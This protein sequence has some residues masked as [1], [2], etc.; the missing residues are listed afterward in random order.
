M[1]KKVTILDTKA[2]E[3]ASQFMPALNA[4]YELKSLMEDEETGT[5]VL[6]VKYPAGFINKKHDHPCAHGMFVLKGILHTSEGD[7]APGAFA[8]FPEGAVMWHGATAAEAVE[9]V[10][11]TNKKFDINYL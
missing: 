3:W 11:V 7:F 5:T 10:F 6:L 1:E 4:S 2:M 9:F 8:W